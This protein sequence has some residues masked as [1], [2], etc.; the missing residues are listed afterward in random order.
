MSYWNSADSN[1]LPRSMM[2]DDGPP[3]RAIQPEIVLE[4]VSAVMLGR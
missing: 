3:N 2:T 1:R 4:I